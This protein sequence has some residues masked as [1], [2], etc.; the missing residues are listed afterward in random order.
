M[1]TLAT[2]SRWH[3]QSDR[4]RERE[5]ESDTAILPRNANTYT[6]RT[7]IMYSICRYLRVRNA[8]MSTRRRRDA[9]VVAS[10]T[11]ITITTIADGVG[12]V[13]RKVSTR[14]E[15][16]TQKLEYI[17]YTITYPFGEATNATGWRAAGGA[18][19]AEMADGDATRKTGTSIR[20]DSDD[21]G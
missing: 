13:R 11:N 16:R 17:I 15:M 14:E 8:M 12:G 18:H 6:K 10:T 9:L 4:Q 2:E 1:T 7:Y 5:R 3:I 20:K 19:A 21:K